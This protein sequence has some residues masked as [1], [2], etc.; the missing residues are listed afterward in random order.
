MSDK[1][2]GGE[3]EQLSQFSQRI[4][5]DF[6][7][8]LCTILGNAELLSVDGSDDLRLQRRVNSIRNSASRGVEMTRK[9]QGF[10]AGDMI[11]PALFDATEVLCED[12]ARFRSTL[13]GTMEF[14]VDIPPKTMF[15]AERSS[16][17]QIVSE[18]LSNARE[19][20]KPMGKIRIEVQV[21]EAGNGCLRVT[22]NGPGFPDSLEQSDLVKPFV[23]TGKPGKGVGLAFVDARLKAHGGH[24]RLFNES[25][26]VVECHFPAQVQIEEKE[27]EVLSVWVVEDEPALLDFIVDVLDTKGF[28]V[29][30]FSD[31]E[32]LL[33]A[34]SERSESPDVLL[35][36]VILPKKSGPDLLRALYQRGFQGAVLWSSGL[37]AQA[38]DLVVEGSV[39]FLQK[40]YTASELDGAIRGLASS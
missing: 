8:L 23:S 6:N 28:T 37:T 1:P 31:S 34:Y 27:P 17:Q 20:S 4:A 24:V 38:A 12:F 9:L 11:N 26:A 5:H 16:V 29:S 32:S 13:P 36:D 15:F 22:D 33:D 21:D 2:T 40:P 39:G 10:G 3:P 35:L 25:G 18:L 19:F 30:A 14:V 7:N